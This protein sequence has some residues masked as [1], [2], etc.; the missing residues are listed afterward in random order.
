MSSAVDWHGALQVAFDTTVELKRSLRG[1]R[2]REENLEISGKIDVVDTM[3]QHLM[4]QIGV[5]SLPPPP[6]T[7]DL[8][9][10]K[11]AMR[12]ARTLRL[13]LSKLPPGTDAK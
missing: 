5:P 7:S 6:Q 2:G 11:D 1:L 13:M 9:N 12:L 8:S 4:R 3:L 10:L